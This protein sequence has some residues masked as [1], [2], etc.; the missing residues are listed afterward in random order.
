MAAS[1]TPL[2]RPSLK[3]RFVLLAV[4]GLLAAPPAA[5]AGEPVDVTYASGRLTIHCAGT[6]L[7][8]VLEQV[9]SAV[10]LALVVDDS[11]KRAPLT[12]DIE[13]QPV[14]LA[15]ELLLEGRG[16]TYAMSLSP[17]GQNVVQMY[18]G[19]GTEAKDA[20]AASGGR[21]P[22]AVAAAGPRRPEAV[23]ALAARASMAAPDVDDDAEDPDEEDEPSPF[24]GMAESVSGLPSTPPA[25][26]LGPASAPA[27]PLGTPPVPMMLP[28]S[29]KPY[30]PVL[31][32]F[33]QPIP[34]PQS[35]PG[36]PVQQ[37]PGA[38]NQ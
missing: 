37:K 13:A 30:Y 20:G 14:Q 18:V 32:P 3:P 9:G 29:N 38:V 25:P 19:A 12:A 1:H 23:A 11:V 35:S 22:G 7:A 8:D 6:P 5:R 36:A 21:R 10:G 15:L 28:G 26:V 2:G 34:M 17:D 27:A 16:V 4:L 33:G 24:A 31:D